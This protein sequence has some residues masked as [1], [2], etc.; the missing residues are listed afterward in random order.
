MLNEILPKQG[1]F[2]IKQANQILALIHLVNLG[3]GTSKD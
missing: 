1:N 2:M 3:K